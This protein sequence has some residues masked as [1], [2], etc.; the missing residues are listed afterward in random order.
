VLAALAALLGCLGQ[1]AAADSAG[2]LHVAPAGGAVFPA[3][4]LVLSVPDRG[5]LSASQVHITENGSPVS[6]AAV[7]PIAKAGAHD[8]GVVLAIDAGP[9][10]RGAPLAEAMRAA[11][12]L[13]AQRTGMQELGVITFDQRATVALPLTDDPAQID[14]V[15]SRTPQVG[16]QAYTYNAVIAA[17]NQLAAAKIAAGA[18]ILLSDGTSPG[19]KPL[20]G[21]LV[22]ASA[23]GSAA[24]SA[25]AQIY[26]VGLRDAS[27]APAR[28]A[29]LARAGGGEFIES[30]SGELANVF[31]RIEAGLTS[32]YVVRYRSAAPLGRQ[33]QVR[34][35][36]DGSSEAATLT[37]STPPAPR[38]PAPARHERSFWGSA[39][40]L[41]VISC[42]AALLLAIAFVVFLVPRVRR[43]SLRTRV[44]Q[45]TGMGAAG[46]QPQPQE[47]QRRPRF[48]VLER[49]LEHTRWWESFR[50]DVE[51]ARI[52]RPAVEL[53]ALYGGVTLALAL[54]FAAVLGSPVLAL[55]VLGLGPLLLRSNVRRR[56]RKQREQFLAQ[57]PDHLQELAS[58][59]RSGHSLVSGLSAMAGAA[60][61]PSRGEWERV[62]A[63][64]RLG[65]PL[66]V[67]LKP[68]A[69]RMECRDVDQVALVARLQQ[70][71][72]G[73]M[74]DVIERV[75]DGIRERADLRR[76]LTS[77]TA[78]ARLSRWVVTSLPPALVL[79]LELINPGYLEPLFNTTTGQVVLALAIVMLIAASF[80]MR[81]I[82]DIKA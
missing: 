18:V 29:L 42:A 71:T 22:T 4:A 79:V 44:G 15:L 20:P 6:G 23:I 25:H 31:T 30:T 27:Y 70:R 36:V 16:T 21:H 53:V 64:E 58:T 69:E 68:L 34:V 37:Y 56:L 48:R 65:V 80:I 76:E 52:E 47:Q 74:A 11:R 73:N 81:A 49:A 50:S 41:V 82:T 35:T 55:V 43:G 8:F 40:A 61:E 2:S 9:T 54:L 46:A 63:D 60:S 28:M 78:Q 13:A 12:A 26:T 24:S 33:V 17:V 5:T 19:A 59:M 45:F 57:L 10:M 32:A 77:L 1:P 72:G 51:I 38:T 75:A 7:T 62:L 39:T 67:A 66:D 3:R 14:R